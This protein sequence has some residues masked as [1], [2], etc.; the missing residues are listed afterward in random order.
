MSES[1]APHIDHHRA[2]DLTG[3]RP[4]SGADARQSN[5][6]KK[7]AYENR[8]ISASRRSRV[9]SLGSLECS[10]QYPSSGVYSYGA[11]GFP[12]TYPQTSSLKNTVSVEIGHVLT[13]RRTETKLLLVDDDA[14]S[15]QRRACQ[16]MFVSAGRTY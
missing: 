11:V 1:T 5:G 10:I 7:R 14:D 16:N 12:Q 6:G 2:D 9:T 13:T 4:M 3:C 8:P 15:S